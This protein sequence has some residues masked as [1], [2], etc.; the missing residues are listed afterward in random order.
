VVGYFSAVG[1]GMSSEETLWEKVKKRFLNS[2]VGVA[3]LVILAV[4]GVL[5][6][7][8]GI[9]G[10]VSSHFGSQIPD[11]KITPLSAPDTLAPFPGYSVIPAK[12]GTDQGAAVYPQG[13]TVIINVAHDLKG[14]ATITIDKLEINIDEFIPEIQAALDYKASGDKIIGHGPSQPGVFQAVL[15]G[16][17]VQAGRVDSAGRIAP[18]QSNDFF[19][20]PD[21]TLYKVSKSDDAQP[22]VVNV[23]AV[24][25]GLYR[26]SF[27]LTYSVLGHLRQQ[28]TTPP[29][30]IYADES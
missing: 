25:T 7:S 23:S 4:G 16:T 19:N 15:L 9:W 10:Q 27:T 22:F 3:A 18:S 1:F 28:R 2:F 14:D 29:V 5:T 30:L 24:Q 20:T 13:V 12:I 11:L 17:K 21:H 8:L 6:Q 26:I